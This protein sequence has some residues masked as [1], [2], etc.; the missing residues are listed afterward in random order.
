MDAPVGVAP[1]RKPSR[2][3]HARDDSNLDNMPRPPTSSSDQNPSIARSMSRYRRKRPGV[4]SSPAIPGGPPD[5]VALDTRGG[6]DVPPIPV[7]HHARHKP[8]VDEERLREKHRLDAM[9]QLTGGNPL[10]RPSARPSNEKKPRRA[11]TKED[12]ATVVKARETTKERRPK[13][14]PSSAS[15]DRK[16]FFQKVGLK[17]SRSS[18]SKDHSAPRYIGV[19][20]GGIVPGTDAPVSAVNAGERHVLV[21]YGHASLRYPF[22]PTTQVSDILHSAS[23]T[24]SSEINPE[25]F[26]LVETFRQIGLD[27]PLRRYEHIR[28]IMNSWSH[29][30]DDNRLTV[31]PPSN[32]DVQ[33]NLD[34]Q[35]HT[36][37]PSETTV[38]MYY[39]QRP[40]KWDKRYVTLRSDGQITMSKKESLKDSTNICHMSDY[41]IYTPSA[42]AAAKDIKPPKRFCYAIKSQ[43]KSTMF[44]ST[45]NFV[46]FFSTNDR[47][48]ADKWHRA[49]HHWRSWYLINTMGAT[50][51]VE[52]SIPKRTPTQRRGV[53]RT[54]NES[55][56]VDQI[57]LNDESSPIRSPGNSR[58]P[59]SQ[60]L[61]SRKKS[62]REPSAPP[63]KPFPEAIAINT[64]LDE[65]PEPAPL[66]PGMNPE[67]I[68]AETFA[69]TSLLGR[70]YTQRRQAMQER[71]ERE[72][73]EKQDPWL[74]HSQTVSDMPATGTLSRS[75]SVNQ[76]NKPLVDLTPVFHEPPQHTR[77][78]RGV[79]IE[80]GRQLIDGATG[81]DLT[82]GAMAVPSSQAWRRPPVPP[83]PQIPP[84]ASGMPSRSNTV[85]ST[86]HGSQSKRPGTGS[87]GGSPTSPP[88]V[89]M[90]N[91]LLAQSSQR[92]VSYDQAPKGR[93]VATG[94]RNAAR[95]LLDLAPENPFVEGSLLHQA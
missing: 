54:S 30:S 74:Y 63:T 15:T 44:L 80:P 47:A 87:G 88:D 53:P 14:N 34:A 85:R 22:S 32:M 6:V 90:P 81:P 13:S 57:P 60:D 70:S 25:A 82:P 49:V 95:P 92:A 51:A 20:G 91:T 61:F 19:G 52:E 56:L 39:S 89:F 16:S 37:S 31:V 36:E 27:R 10:S 76:K 29:D 66:V 86:R 59:S 40:R 11:A 38:L 64:R 17:K 94:D 79:A 24:L 62:T 45:E 9:D 43:Q 83:V 18:P 77:K 1:T 2:Y 48:I 33:V 93:G 28:E 7:S 21:Q 41:D 50:Q 67:E 68:E 35:G 73:R 84:Q 12:I 71:E 65:H 8:S 5:A 72:K 58:P 3:R 23:K 4:E 75:T 42:R 46:H 26:I 69:P 55:L 78:G